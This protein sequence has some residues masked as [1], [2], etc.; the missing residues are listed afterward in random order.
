VI[1]SSPS[2]HPAEPVPGR[3]GLRRRPS[4]HSHPDH[5]R[6]YRES[7][8]VDRQR[9][10]GTDAGNQRPPGSET[11]QL[12]GLHA[13]HSQACPKGVSLTR[14]DVCNQRRLGGLPGRAHGH[15]EHQQCRD[16]PKRHSSYRHPRQQHRPDQITTDQQ[17]T[18]RKPIGQRADH[19]A[20]ERRQIRQRVHAGRQQARSSAIENQ[21]GQRDPRQLIAKERLHICQPQPP[22]LANR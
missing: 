5:Q 12:R 9:R 2:F 22:E 7:G 15:H 8:G 20:G 10:P 11:D 6:R 17:R 13:R 3:A 19:Q 14:Q 21:H 18:T 4:T 1:T 16:Y